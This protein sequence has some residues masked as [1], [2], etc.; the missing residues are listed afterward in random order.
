MIFF[1][2]LLI[3]EVIFLIIDVYGLVLGISF[4][5]LNSDEYVSNFF[6]VFFVFL[7]LFVKLREEDNCIK[8]FCIRILGFF[9]I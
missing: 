2:D 5:I 3:V 1:V 9:V 6:V 4:V 8:K 7:E